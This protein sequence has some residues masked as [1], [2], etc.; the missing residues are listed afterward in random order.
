MLALVS[1][2]SLRTCDTMAGLGPAFL[3]WGFDIGE[4]LT[5]VFFLDLAA[6]FF[7]AFFES[8]RFD[9]TGAC[10]PVSRSISTGELLE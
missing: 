2:T 7:L 6:L 3:R 5:P 9:A 10:G 4:L 1:S 8:S